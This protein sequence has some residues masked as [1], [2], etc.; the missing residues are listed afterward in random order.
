MTRALSVAVWVAE[1]GAGVLMLRAVFL[2]AWAMAAFWLLALVFLELE[3]WRAAWDARPERA[4]TVVVDARHVILAENPA[5]TPA[6][7]EAMWA[8][9][10]ERLHTRGGVVS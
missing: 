3:T 7:V 4:Q 2:E 1:S 5:H 6:D 8:R 9:I 10:R